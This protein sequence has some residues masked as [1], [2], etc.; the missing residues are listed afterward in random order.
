MAD[1]DDDKGRRAR[2]ALIDTTAPNPARVGD[3]L[4]GGRNNFAA[5]RKIAQAMMAVAPVVGAIQPAMRAFR[6][7]VVRYLITEAGVRQFLDIGTG[8]ETAGHTHELAQS[9]DP[10]CRVVYV[11]SDP[12]VLAH[13]RALMQSSTEG[14]VYFVDA[15]IRDSA[16]ILAG[17]RATLDFGR[18]VALLLLATLAFTPDTASAAAV[19]SSL[20]A[21][22]VPGSYVAIHHQASDL[23]PAMEVAVRRW[24]RQA[25]RRLTLRSA[26]QVASLVDGLELIPPGLVPICEWRPQPGDPSFEDIVPVHGAVARRP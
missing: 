8:L 6:H 25:T 26:K 11:D 22:M 2:A 7:R 16:G 19:V 3:Y 15:D 5:D 18:P 21:D 20:L 23:H 10:R 14:A 17:A 12:V 13:G 24:N 4:F 1:E 9:I